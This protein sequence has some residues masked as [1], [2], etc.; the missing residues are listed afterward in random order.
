MSASAPL[1]K[2]SKNTGKV[3]ADCTSATQSG[4][5]VMEVIIQAAATSFIHMQVLATNQV[6]HN[7]RN[8]GCLIGPQGESDSVDAARGLWVISS[9]IEFL[10]GV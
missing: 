10:L 6:L 4:V 8:T 2:P 1:G 9:G 5:V 3:D 7:M